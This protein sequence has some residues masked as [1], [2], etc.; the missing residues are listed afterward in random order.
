MR[1]YQVKKGIEISADY[2]ANLT[3][4]VLGNAEII[5]DHV[6]ASYPGIK[7]IDLYTD[8]KKLFAQTENDPDA[9]NLLQTVRIFN[10]L[11]ERITGYSSKERK[12]HFSKTK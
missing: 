9:T 12:K 5:Q 3:K 11:I 7:K 6:I 1:E 8:G 4:E 2:I 10:T